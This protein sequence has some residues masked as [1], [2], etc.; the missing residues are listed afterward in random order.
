MRKGTVVRFVDDDDEG[1][2]VDFDGE[3]IIVDFERDGLQEC[4]ADEL[5]KIGFDSLRAG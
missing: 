2:V 1:V 5:H 4:E 3:L